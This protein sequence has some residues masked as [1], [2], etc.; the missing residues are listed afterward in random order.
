MALS[1]RNCDG[2]AL[3]EAR[4]NLNQG[5]TSVRLTPYGAKANSFIV[6]LSIRRP[7]ETRREGCRN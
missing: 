6:Y 3:S 4:A 7:M 2:K 1:S 5:N